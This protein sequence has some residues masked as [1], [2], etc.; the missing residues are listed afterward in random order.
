MKMGPHHREVMDY[1]ELIPSHFPSAAQET[2]DSHYISL[3]NPPSEMGEPTIMKLLFQITTFRPL[4]LSRPIT[5]NSCR[6]I[7]GNGEPTI[8][9]PQSLLAAREINY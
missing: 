6:S 5:L 1:S 8:M 3:V 9:K 7:K 4:K 2:A